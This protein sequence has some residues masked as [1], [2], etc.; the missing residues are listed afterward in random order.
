VAANAPP[1]LGEQRSQ[2]CAKNLARERAIVGAAVAKGVGQR[3]YPLTDRHHR[4]HAVHEVRRGVGHAPAAT[5]RAEAAPLARERH[6]SIVAALVA[7]QAQEAVREEA[8]AQEGAKLLLDEVRRGAL[9]RSC[10]GEKGLELLAD[11][12]V[13]EV[14]LGR[15]REPAAVVLLAGRLRVGDPPG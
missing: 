9:A 3:E 6:E 5:R 11:H 2:E 13:Q 1:Q 7:A 12:A 14:V 4:E 8:A 10:A 15:A